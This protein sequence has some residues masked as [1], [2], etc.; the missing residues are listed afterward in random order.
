M[1]EKETWKIG[2]DRDK[3]EK[4]IKYCMYIQYHKKKSFWKRKNF[5]KQP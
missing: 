2:T 4:L 1:I 5:L 3:L